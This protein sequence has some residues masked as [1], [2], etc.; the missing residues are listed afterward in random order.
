VSAE[1]PRVLVS[2]VV[3]S[4]PMGGVRRHNA[5]LL[6][7]AAEL[8]AAEGGELVLMEGRSPIAFELSAK[9]RRLPSAVPASPPAIRA[10]FEGRALRQALIT[11]E[12][13][14]RQIDLVHLGHMPAPRSLP[15]P[16]THTIH[17]LRLLKS[18]HTPMSRRLVSRHV[19]GAAIKGAALVIT[20]SELVKEQLREQFN[21]DP[22]RVRVVPNG[23]D[24]LEVLPRKKDHSGPLLCVGHLEQRKNV[25]LLIEALALDHQLGELVLIG[26]PK[27]GE[28]ARLKELAASRGV[29]ERV[30]FAG[31]VDDAELTRLYAECAACVFP[32]K[33]E[34]F[35]IGVAEAMRAG[36]PV[37]IAR[38]TAMDEVSQGRCAEFDSDDPADCAGAIHRA[39]KSSPEQLRSA[40]ERS[41]TFS[42]DKSAEALVSAWRTAAEK[43]ASD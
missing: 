17:D 1:A 41:A 29:S 32:S 16:H 12:A 23:S 34:G 5:E 6:P 11:E 37:A 39:I 10:S 26:A 42:W 35:G 13:A 31:V 28:E 40:E 43:K 14:G 20:V 36:A 19:V 38:G 33:L 21:L 18:A 15:V 8:L 24:H 4:Q 7:R 9:I 27:A 30:R 3:L 22:E 25:K 2:G